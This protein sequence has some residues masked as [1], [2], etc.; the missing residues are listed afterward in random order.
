MSVV[1]PGTPAATAGLQTD[2]VVLEFAGI[3]IE[4]E[5]HL[6]NAVSQTE[7]GKPVRMIVWRERKRVTL[8]TVLGSWDA[9]QATEKKTQDPTSSSVSGR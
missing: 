9:Y 7:V 1:H 5:N 6:I 3:P 8:E 4:D 2:D